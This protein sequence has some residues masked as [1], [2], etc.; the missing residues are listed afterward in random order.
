VAARRAGPIALACCVAAGLLAAGCSSSGS[1]TAPT[2]GRTAA[3]PGCGRAPRP[4][5]TTTAA[6]GDV[7]R[8]LVVDGTTRTY[9][10]AVPA[11][12]RPGR[13]TPLIL[14]FHGSGSNAL[15]QSA[16]SQLPARAGAAGYLVATPDAL[17]GQWDLASP[18]TQT[19]DQAFV[20]ALVA[21]LGSRYCLDR[22][23]VFAAG[24][25]L[26]SQ[27]A[28]LLA[29]D[30]TNRIDA[31]GLVSADYLIRPCAGPIPVLAFHGTA[32]P[33]VP[34]GNGATGRSV[35]GIPVVGVQENLAA[36]ARLDGCARTPAVSRPAPGIVRQAWGHCDG[37]STVTLYTVVGGGHTWPG[38][39]VVLSAA[40]F[41]P[42]TEA[43]S[44]TGLMLAF[45]ARA[46]PDQRGR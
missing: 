32:D 9:R 27:F 35:P 20:T 29:C 4:G 40:A 12:Y 13:P 7:P 23:R 3:S 34:Y 37:T 11:G 28:A 15:Q 33:V 41:G 38:S 8:T 17:G 42:T 25:S 1:T 31:V 5:P 36:W 21:D 45:F 22:S 6:F 26:G 44:A 46:G 39:P 43:I 24:I 2:P 19:A 14:L 16:Y 18:G 30:P 10:L